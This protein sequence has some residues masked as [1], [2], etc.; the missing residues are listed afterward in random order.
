MLL[1]YECSI[2]SSIQP[3]IVLREVER[4]VQLVL[5]CKLTSF[6]AEFNVRRVISGRGRMVLNTDDY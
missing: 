2:D 6:R 3:K 4:L 5:Q 1:R